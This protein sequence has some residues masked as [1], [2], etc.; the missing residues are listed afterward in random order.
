V[1]FTE[2]KEGRRRERRKRLKRRGVSVMKL[3][4]LV[5]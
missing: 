2:E 3:T 4:I 1:F 5:F